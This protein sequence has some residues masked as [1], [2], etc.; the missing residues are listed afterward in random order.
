MKIYNKM[1]SIT[2][3][4]ATIGI[5]NNSPPD[6]EEIENSPLKDVLTNAK[7]SDAS[8][9]KIEIFNEKKSG[10]LKVSPIKSFVNSLKE[11][12]ILYKSESIR[13]KGSLNSD[14]SDVVIDLI[15]NK[16]KLEVELGD[17]SRYLIFKEC[18][19][20][21]QSIIN[22]KMKEIRGLIA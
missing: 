22:S 4:D 2:L 18:S 6:A 11:L 12:G 15:K 14:E 9:I 21:V 1:G 16:Y 17:N 5:G 13:V 19:K 3:I 10:G 7:N 20:K 8:R